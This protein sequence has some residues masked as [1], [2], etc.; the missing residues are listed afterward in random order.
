MLWLEMTRTEEHGGPGWGFGDRVWCPSRKR[1]GAKWSHWETVLQV[2]KGDVIVH[3]KGKT[4]KQQFL[5][6]SIAAEDAKETNERPSKPGEWGFAKS[7]YYAALNDYV[8]FSKPINLNEVLAAED[9]RLR[10]YFRRKAESERL[11]LVEQDGRLQCF[12]GGYFSEMT[13]ELAAIIFGPDFSGAPQQSKS[14]AIS[15]ATGQQLALI[16]VRLGQRDF[17]ANVRA[18]YD[19]RCCFPNCGIEDPVFLVGAH[20][21]R[22]ADNPELRGQTSNGLCFCLIH[23]KAFELGLFTLTK[24][25]RIWVN[26]EMAKSFNWAA[27]NLLPYANHKIK[28]GVIRPSVAALQLHWQRLRCIPA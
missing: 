25:G 14:P 9:K 13:E 23:D 26:G 7:F 4:H 6:F 10:D 27:S 24:D 15:A 12:N 22:W 3:L 11:F 8:P 2:K 1:N 20:I 16:K 21:A 17:S 19:D 28:Q 5:G 18:N